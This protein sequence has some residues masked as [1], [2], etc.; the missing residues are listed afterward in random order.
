[1]D[2]IPVG[3]PG[4]RMY[5]GC[6]ARYSAG[7]LCRPGPPRFIGCCPRGA[8][9]QIARAPQESPLL[10]QAL[11]FLERVVELPT[12]LGQL[13]PGLPGLPRLPR[14]P[15]EL[16]D[17]RGSAGDGKAAA[18]SRQKRKAAAAAGRVRSRPPEAPRPGVGEGRHVFLQA[19][20]WESC[21][22][23]GWYNKLEREVG[24]LAAEGFTALW[25]PPP[26]VSVCPQGYL[27]TDLYNLNTPYGSAAELQRLVGAAHWAGL[28]VMADIVLNHRCATQQSPCGLWNRFGEHPAWDEGVITADSLAHYGGRGAPSTGSLYAAAPNID[29]TQP[30]VRNDYATWLAWLRR[31][32]KFDGWRLDF[33]VGFSGVYAG[34]YIERSEPRLAVGEFWDGCEYEEGV[35]GACQDAHRHRQLAW[36]VSTGNRAAAFDFTTKAVLQEAV[37]KRQRW[38]LMDEHGNPPGLIGLSP[39]HAVTFIDNHDTGSSLQ[40]WPFPRAHLQEGY[41][42]V[43]SHPGT[44]CVL[45]DD[46]QDPVCGPSIRQL[47]RMRRRN[48]IHA[49]SKVTIHEARSGLYVAAIDERVL[50]AL[51]PGDWQPTDAGLTDRRWKRSVR[52]RDFTVWEKCGKLSRYSLTFMP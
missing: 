24:H 18:L 3:F 21:H 41:A 30:W 12:G 14:I 17:E 26:S 25:L 27:P 46:M 44:P 7:G 45:Y 22:E 6:G 32:A 9:A 2:A 23:G 15:R 28:S 47:L 31:T 11:P 34:E 20:N 50:V 13:L 42:Y 40:H 19:F 51:G 33:A 10:A 8:H 38:R 5:P 39:A 1:M 16:S 36:C 29:H 37:A 43:L 48:R 4:Q 49:Q 52:G 35:L